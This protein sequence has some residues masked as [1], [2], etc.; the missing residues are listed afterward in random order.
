MNE[1]AQKEEA[2]RTLVPASRVF[3]VDG[4]VRVRLEVPGVARDNLEIRT[5]GSELTIIGRRNK[6]LT[7]GT[8]LRRERLRGDFTKSFSV[9]SSI[10]LEKAD[11]ELA[12]GI[13]TLTLPMKDAAKPR[14]I[15][16]R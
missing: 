3:E 10:D 12:N 16:I 11:A 15:T 7:H 5:E 2:R 14:A 4:K 13:L 6:E 1:I 8:W 9:D